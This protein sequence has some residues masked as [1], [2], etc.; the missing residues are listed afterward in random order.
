MI[1]VADKKETREAV[2]RFDEEVRRRY[3][4][5]DEFLT[6]KPTDR[7]KWPLPAAKQPLRLPL[8]AIASLLRA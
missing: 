1:E 6:M 3:P 7:V 8:F 5:L 2:E 4:R